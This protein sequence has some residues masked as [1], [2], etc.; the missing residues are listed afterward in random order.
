[1]LPKQG[2]K[3]L[4][5]QMAK[6]SYTCTLHSHGTN[7]ASTQML[8]RAG[9]HTHTHAHAQRTE[10]Q[11]GHLV[12]SFIFFLAENVIK[13]HSDAWRQQNHCKI[14]LNSKKMSLPTPQSLLWMADFTPF[15][16]QSL[17]W[18]QY[19]VVKVRNMKHV[20]EVKCISAQHK[21]FFFFN[22][23]VCSC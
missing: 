23:E 15:V 10:G 12:N 5:I 14:M 11:P 6:G 7:T 19:E 3:R 4:K 1:M 13:A 20:R 9:T 22:F 17:T 16:N 21:L 8:M 18:I 2:A